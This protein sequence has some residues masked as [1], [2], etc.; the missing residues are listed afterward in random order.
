MAEAPT[1]Q[2]PF[3]GAPLT[4]EGDYCPNCGSK[5][6]QFTEHRQKMKAYKKAFDETRNTVVAENK[7]DSR[8]AALIA[9]IAVLVALIL[10]E[11]IITRNAYSIARDLRAKQ[12]KRNKTQILTALKEYEDSEQYYAVTEMWEHNALRV[13]N[14]EEGFRE[15]SAVSMVCSSYENIIYS[16]SYLQEFENLYEPGTYDFMEGL[17]RRATNVGDN[18][19]SFLKRYKAYVEDFNPDNKYYSY[20]PDGFTK[21][22]METYALLKEN[23]RCIVSYYFDIPYEEMDEFDKLTPARMN[24]R[25]VEAMEAKYAQE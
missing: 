8:K 20:H 23:A 17:D 24:T 21:E 15:Y 1:T 10:G 16:I 13:L 2:C 22:H 18:Y 12:S 25:L 4:V 5:K 19:S 9:V 6:Q 11:I 3:C 14:E 7:R